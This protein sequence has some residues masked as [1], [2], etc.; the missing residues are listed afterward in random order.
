[1]SCWSRAVCLCLWIGVVTLG[2]PCL[3]SA[4]EQRLALVIGNKSYSPS[5]GPLTLTHADADRVA[6]ALRAAGFGVVL[7]KDLN[8]DQM[9][10][11]IRAF[12]ARLRAA[13][14]AAVGFFYY[15][16]HGASGQ[17]T[18]G[19][20]NFLIPVGEQITDFGEVSYVGINLNKVVDLLAATGARAIFVVSDAC[21]DSFPFVGTKGPTDKGFEAISKAGL[22]IAYA[23]DQGSTTP[24]DGL[25]STALA[26]E[27][28]RPGQ[29][30]LTAF[31]EA[32]QRVGQRRG[33]RNIPYVGFALVEPFCFVSCAGPTTPP[34][35]VAQLPAVVAAP[36]KSATRPPGT[37]PGF[38]PVVG[39]YPQP[40]A[41]FK[42]CADCPEMVVVPAGKYMRG[43][44]QAER[45]WV[46]QQ[47]GTLDWTEDEQP[48]REVTIP[49][50]FAVAR[51]E[52]TKGLYARFVA[53]SPGRD[54]KGCRVWTGSEWK[55]DDARSWR[56]PGFVQ[57]D[58]H[59]VACVSFK[60]AIAF[61]GWLNQRAQTR[62][63]SL[64]SE[65]EWEYAARARKSSWRY[66]GDDADNKAACGFANGAD[67][68]AQA[69][70]NWANVL[71]CADGS[72]Y[73]SSVG[74]KTSND[75]GLHDMLGNVWEWTQDC[76]K[77]SYD[78]V[79]TDGAAFPGPPCDYRVLR[80]GS[81]VN[82]PRDLR[83][84]NRYRYAPG[85]RGG[86]SGF[87]VARTLTP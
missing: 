69:Q 39:S 43:S 36:P 37:P 7:K 46:V 10:A 21:R 77:D 11:E 65:A 79:P 27:L 55:Q 6:A 48:R 85:N 64:L 33:N 24:D 52:V 20:A 50:P 2:W 63:Y 71:S 18:E 44:T 78:G 74:S 3:S 54:A 40:G 9:D 70:F 23:T 15:S 82:N 5:V 57:G 19:R 51:T 42:D 17:T 67:Q 75:F 26:A 45:D 59:P 41:V 53:E 4:Q 29:S 35:V 22:L 1:M 8:H 13:G 14:S 38:V 60:D 81:W 28:V 31:G 34:S 80:G 76:Y 66:W 49:R 72:A 73:T 47:G 16:G 68:T 58:D 25:F 61:V 32:A 84:A 56:D 87:R 30:A 12:A 62:A 83:A 86:D